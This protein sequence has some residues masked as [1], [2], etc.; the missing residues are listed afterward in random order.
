MYSDCQ[1]Q[2]SSA[3]NV[4]DHITSKK[5][6]SRLWWRSG[7][8]C[9]ELFHPRHWATWDWKQGWGEQRPAGAVGPGVVGQ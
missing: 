8:Y 9:D 1:N 7:E 6:V 4:W 2:V 3:G 5:H